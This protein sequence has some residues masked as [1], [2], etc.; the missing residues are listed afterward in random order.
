LLNFAR[1][2]EAIAAPR[3]LILQ[4]LSETIV[5]VILRSSNALSAQIKELV[6]GNNQQQGTTA[7]SVSSLQGNNEAT[8]AAPLVTMAMQAIFKWE[9]HHL[10]FVQTV[11]AYGKKS[12][13]D[14]DPNYA[15]EFTMATKLV[16]AVRLFGV[17]WFRL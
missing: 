4:T 8:V 13:D 15:K 7:A 1:A 2:F 3:H 16:K 17:V 14:N 5:P 12:D 9:A 11:L 10:E 6:V